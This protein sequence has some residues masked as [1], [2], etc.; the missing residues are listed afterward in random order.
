M[1]LGFIGV[2]VLVGLVAVLVS[3]DSSQAEISIVSPEDGA[4]VE[5]GKVAVR[6]RVQDVEVAEWE[7]LIRGPHTAG[8]WMLLGRG[9]SE[10]LYSAV[11]GGLHFL[12][13]IQPGRYELTLKVTDRAGV[14]A[15]KRSEFRIGE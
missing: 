13:L 3:T 1:I 6:I 2:F 14:L 4:L 7:L 10:P 8:E 11:G 5:P 12:D 9:G 15:E